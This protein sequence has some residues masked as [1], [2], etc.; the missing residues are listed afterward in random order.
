MTLPKLTHGTVVAYLALFCALTGG[1]Y[2][3]VKLPANSVKSKQVKDGSLLATDFATNQLPAGA[4][5]DAGAAGPK[6]DAGAPGAPGPQGE[7][8]PAGPAS[9]GPAGPKGEA[10]PTGAQGPKGDTGAQGPKGDTGPAGPGGLTFENVPRGYGWSAYALDDSTP[11]NKKACKA[12]PIKSAEAEIPLMF[13]TYGGAIKS[14]YGDCS[15]GWGMVIPKTGVYTVTLNL[16]W[17]ANNTGARGI[18]IRR[19]GEGT[20]G[21]LGESRITAAQGTVTAQ[22]V[23]ATDAFNAGDTIQFYAYQTSGGNL[24]L[25]NDGRTSVEAHFV[26]PTH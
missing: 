15:K 7:R 12:A 22:S 9:S 13:G 10:G 24:G 3:A 16:M 1:A 2:A 4:K 18:G 8:G 21:Y 5:G 11:E 26:A 17:Q 19:V 23:T 25:I 20:N 14:T 6:G